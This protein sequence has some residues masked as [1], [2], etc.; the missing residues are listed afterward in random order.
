M[1]KTRHEGAGTQSVFMQLTHICPI[2]L[3]ILGMI[4]SWYYLITLK[5]PFC[6]PGTPVSQFSSVKR[7][8]TQV[9]HGSPISGKS[10]AAELHGHAWTHGPSWTIDPILVPFLCRLS[11]SPASNRLYWRWQWQ[12]TCCEE[13][14]A[15]FLPALAPSSKSDSI[16]SRLLRLSG[17][18]CRFRHPS[19]SS[20]TWRLYRWCLALRITRT[21]GAFQ[22]TRE[23]SKSRISTIIR[24]LSSS[25][26]NQNDCS[27][28]V[29]RRCKKSKFCEN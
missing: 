15:T 2:W 11:W 24:T 1:E 9:V 3:L 20:G 16:L 6:P 26:F 22:G 21:I 19:K 13:W 8:C 7:N 29:R 14:W 18:H 4:Q 17:F 10:G 28:G 12:E 23:L 5:I 25:N 27:K